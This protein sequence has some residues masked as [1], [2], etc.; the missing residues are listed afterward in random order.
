[1]YLTAAEFI[2]RYSEREAILL[3]AESSQTTVNTARLERGLSDASAQVDAYL[4]RRFALPLV[5]AASQVPIVPDMIKRLTGD[6]AR[7]LL[8]GTHVR[9][10]DAIRNRYKDAIDQLDRIAT[11]KVS[12]GVELVMASSL[13]APVGG[14]SAVRAG[15]RLFGDDQM[16]G[17]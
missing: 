5:D 3:S 13:S 15:G 11:G 7:Y 6:I 2:E 10:T 9:E 8:T 12:M 4:A 17:Y 1:M 14:A 16:R